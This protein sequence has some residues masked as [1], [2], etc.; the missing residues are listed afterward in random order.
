MMKIF[1]VGGFV[2]DTI[3]NQEPNDRDYV[4]VG[5][6]ADDVENLVGRGFKQ[7]GA[8]FP[9]FL[10]PITG[11]EHALAR[12]ERKIGVG[13]RGFETFTSPD[14]TIEDDLTRRDFTMNAMALDEH[15]NLVDPFNGQRDLKA[16][17][18]RH[19]SPAF[20][21]DP[22]R[23]LRACRFVARF[24]F[25]IHSSTKLLM[26]QL[27]KSGELDNL[28]RER[29]WV[30]L[31]KI[32]N[33][34]FSMAGVKALLDCGAGQRLFGDWFGAFANEYDASQFNSV[35]PISK[36]VFLNRFV[37]IDLDMIKRLQDWKVPN[38]F[39]AAL[40]M[41][42]RNADT[43]SQWNHFASDFR[44]EMELQLLGDLGLLGNKTTFDNLDGAFKLLILDWD[45][46]KEKIQVSVAKVKSVDCA[47]I[48]ENIK[49]GKLVAATIKAARIVALKK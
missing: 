6:T 2:R 7:V 36:F 43:V 46:I 20:A 45:K 40:I 4:I 22:L 19:V 30:E 15:G 28:A 17:V 48:A 26:K 11:D 35:S 41:F 32:L 14:L 10:C 31:E 27:V 37:D 29:V 21:E 23:V 13:Y 5:A 33:S 9:V 18:I 42:S 38:D 1:T 47:T 44:A 8:D 34:K 39:I 16:G 3:L 49:D 12:T 24:G 25:K